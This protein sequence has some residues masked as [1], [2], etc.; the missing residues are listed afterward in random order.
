MYVAAR[1]TVHRPEHL[2]GCCIASL[3][4]Q[5]AH[6]HARLQPSLGM[7]LEA[8]MCLGMYTPLA[9]SAMWSS[10]LT[11]ERSPYLQVIPPG[12][13]FEFIILGNVQPF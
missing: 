7:R 10:H 1:E 13:G 3:H 12:E 11:T 9:Q 5:H 4:T 8:T 2:V 6:L